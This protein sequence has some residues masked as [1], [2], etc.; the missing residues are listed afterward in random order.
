MA[1]RNRKNSHIK[2]IGLV[3]GGGDC[4]GLNAVIR[5][6]VISAINRGWEVY[7]I[8]RGFEGLLYRNRVHLLNTHDVRGIIHTGGTI[9]VTT[10]RGN[11]FK[12]MVTE[13]GETRF[14]DI[15]DKVVE[16]FHSL[17]LESLIVIGGD[18]TLS[19]ASDLARKGIPVIGVPKSIDNDLMATEVT[20]GFSTA[21]AT[22]TDAIDK[23]HATAASH[24]RVM[25]VEVMG[26]YAGWIALFSGVAGG[27]DV[28]LIPEIPYR[29]E[30]IAEKL[31]DRW[32]RK[33]NFAI[34]V[35]A[36]GAREVGGELIY[37]PH[38]EDEVPRLGGIAEHLARD[39]GKLTGYQTR[40]LV[41]G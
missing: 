23:L 31:H 24:E 7:G 5:A 11:P 33:R 13:D 28:I 34:V 19:I 10:N 26:R 38:E 35:A 40:S 17:E 37:Q 30:K 15:S 8:E 1:Q 21:V 41:L 12:L 14:I 9:L 22:A 16:Q 20:F 4:P 27:A 39:L 2:K 3:T 36:E 6:V 32:Q 18:G 25:I 29:L